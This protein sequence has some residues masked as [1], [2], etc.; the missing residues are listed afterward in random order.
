MNQ[1]PSFFGEIETAIFALR[2]LRLSYTDS[3]ALPEKRS[4]D[5]SEIVN[6]LNEDQQFILGEILG[7]DLLPLDGAEH[8]PIPTW[9]A[10]QRL[11]QVQDL[12]TGGWKKYAENQ[13]VI[14]PNQQRDIIVG[15]VVEYLLAAIDDKE[16]AVRVKEHG[17]E[18]ITVTSSS[19]WLSTPREDIAIVVG[20][21][22]LSAFEKK[23]GI[24]IRRAQSQGHEM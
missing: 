3:Q 14:L 8:D 2:D 24:H 13:F 17:K 11:A 21:K 15:D 4:A 5:I 1:Q 23:L 20:E 7:F 16:L 9:L 18:K 22:A 12:L 19:A 10:T 6:Q